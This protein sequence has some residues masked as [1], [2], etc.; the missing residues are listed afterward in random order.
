MSDKEEPGAKEEPDAKK[1]KSRDMLFDNLQAYTGELNQSFI[2]QHIKQQILIRE[3]LIVP[4]KDMTP[5]TI[6]AIIDYIRQYNEIAEQR[7]LMRGKL[8]QYV[9]ITASAH[10]HLLIED[11]TL[12]AA[13]V[14]QIRDESTILEVWKK[15]YR[16]TNDGKQPL[17]REI[18]SFERYANQCMTIS[19]VSCGVCGIF[20]EAEGPKEDALEELRTLS[21]REVEQDTIQT[22]MSSLVESRIPITNNVMQLIIYFTRHVLRATFDSNY[23]DIIQTITDADPDKPWYEQIQEIADSHTSWSSYPINAA[24]NL[25]KNFTC[26]ASEDEPEQFYANYGMHVNLIGKDVLDI[27]IRNIMMTPDGYIAYIN[28][29][30]GPDRS[31]PNIQIAIRAIHLL[32]ETRQTNIAALLAIANAF[33][34]R[35][36]L[37]DSGCEYYQDQGRVKVLRCG[38]VVATGEAKKKSEEPPLSVK[39]KQAPPDSQRDDDTLW[40]QGQGLGGGNRRRRTTKKKPRRRAK[41]KTNRPKRKYKYRYTKRKHNN[42]RFTR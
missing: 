29:I 16:E 19:Q 24:E 26:E 37:F 33:K 28:T 34:L 17:K 3:K 15:L 8:G 13:V 32:H 31:N 11:T 21:S 42:K 9:V 10:A 39:N 14:E 7:T 27:S 6:D 25:C 20:E 5:D 18:D 41:R 30:N 22:F 40:K 2:A 36:A 35:L 38:K 4:Y 12:G 1:P 23:R